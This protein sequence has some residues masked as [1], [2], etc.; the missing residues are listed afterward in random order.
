MK[1]GIS[2]ET[3]YDGN[4]N[5]MLRVHKEKGKLSL[6]DIQ[7][8]ATEW[9]EDYYFLVMKCLDSEGMNWFD[10]DLPGD[11]AELYR[12]TDILKAWERVRER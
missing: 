2:C 6:E 1:K 8:A 3:T 7:Q 5:W 9:E 11:C 12:A 10:D 4:G